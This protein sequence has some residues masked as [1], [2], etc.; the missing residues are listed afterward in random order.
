[1]KTK[2]IL[3]FCGA[4]AL[5]AC[6]KSY[7][8]SDLRTPASYNTN[9]LRVL[10]GNDETSQFLSKYVGKF[11]EDDFTES[12]VISADGKVVRME[13]RQV[14]GGSDSQIPYPTVCSYIKTGKIV[15]VEKR[16]LADRQQYIDFATHV[17]K[18]QYS[19]IALTNEL[20]SSTTV[21]PN[22]Q[23]FLNEMKGKISRQGNIWYSYY[24][25]L[26]SDDSFRIQSAGGGDYQQGGPRTPSTLDEIYTKMQQ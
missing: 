8:N 6:D 12:F 16:D 23:T 4:L 17:I 14:S 19:N 11:V 25:E 13:V 7:K 10:E 20:E 1:M 5:T 21:N 24:S 15:Q 18:V 3:L 26:L 9:G 22:C 2:F